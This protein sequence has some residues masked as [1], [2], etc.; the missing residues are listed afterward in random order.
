MYGN[1]TGSL[2]HSIHVVK[3]IINYYRINYNNGRGNCPT[4]PK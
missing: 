4:T 1:D 2:S 3:Y